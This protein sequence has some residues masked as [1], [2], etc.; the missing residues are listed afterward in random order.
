MTRL[1]RAAKP[2][3]SEGAVHIS[4][5]VCDVRDG[6]RSGRRPDDDVRRRVRTVTA[7]EVLRH[8]PF[9]ALLSGRTVSVLGNGLA[10]IAIAFAVPGPRPAPS[11]DLGIVLAA[12]SIPQVVFLLFGGVLADRLPRHLVL[13][14]SN[15]VCGG[16]QA[17]AAVLLLTDH[18]SIGALVAIEAVNGASAAFIFPASA[19]LLPQTVPA[20]DLQPAN[21]LFRMASTAA[22]VAGA[23]MGGVLVAAVGPGWGFAAD[24]VS[25]LVAAACFAAIRV[26]PARPDAVEQRP[27]STCG[28]AGPSSGPGPG[29]G[30]WCSRSA[31]STQCTPPGGSRSARSS[32]MRPSAG[33]AG[34]SCSAPRPPACSWPVSCCC[35][36]GS[37]GRCS[38]A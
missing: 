24:A 26:A 13:V 11:S 31:S 4:A 8:R 7:R 9:A 28:R 22:M 30:W 14:V 5:T 29:S 17:L 38:S 36:C 15:I 3:R 1:H 19:G 32:P 35:G 34:G 10:T 27:R 21:V 37:A 23:A 12:R 6:R 16:T 33:R 18:A 25:F 20:R 2:R